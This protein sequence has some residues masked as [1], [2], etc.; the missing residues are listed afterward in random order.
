MYGQTAGMYYEYYNVLH[1]QV[2]TH[3]LGCVHV[4]CS[5]HNTVFETT[6]DVE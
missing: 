4:R 6:P 5:T 3:L 2:V 1:I